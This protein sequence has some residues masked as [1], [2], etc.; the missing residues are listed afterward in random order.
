M[1]RDKI[2]CE[3]LD[4]RVVG[5]HIM[6]VGSSEI[7]QG[8]AVAVKMGATKADF[9]RCVVWSNELKNTALRVDRRFRSLTQPIYPNKTT[10]VSVIFR[11]LPGSD[12]S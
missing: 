12:Q 10:V 1:L 11:D 4:M 8:F 6:G 3:G 9:D 2:V 5:L 7:F